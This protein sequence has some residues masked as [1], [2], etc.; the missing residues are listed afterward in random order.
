MADEKKKEPV[1]YKIGEQEV[2]LE[3]Y[4]K[5]IDLNVSEYMKR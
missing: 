3:R 1:K 2:D 5:N 4:I